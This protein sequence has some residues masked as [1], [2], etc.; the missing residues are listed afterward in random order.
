M[1]KAHSEC[2]IDGTSWCRSTKMQP[3]GRRIDI[4]EDI[5]ETCFY[6]EEEF[7]ADRELMIGRE[8]PYL[9]TFAITVNLV[10]ARR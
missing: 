1:S 4:V 9:I 3:V 6:T 7:F 2:G 10:V 8:T 5:V